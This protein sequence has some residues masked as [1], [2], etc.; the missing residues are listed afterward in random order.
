MSKIPK[1]GTRDKT[2]SNGLY[3]AW[4]GGAS[5]RRCGCS[6]EAEREGNQARREE[7][8][9]RQRKECVQRTGGRRDIGALQGVGRDC[10]EESGARSG[11][12]TAIQR[13]TQKG[14]ACCCSFAVMSDFL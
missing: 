12:L 4:K 5:Q 9:S 1:R 2:A 6:H 7:K 3:S 10:G 13:R 8:L 11:L 14:V